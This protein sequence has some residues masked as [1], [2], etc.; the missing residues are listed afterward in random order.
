MG[1]SVLEAASIAAIKANAKGNLAIE[2][3][4]V[5]APPP[6][7]PAPKPRILGINT[8][9]SWGEAPAKAFIKAGITSSRIDLG[10]GDSISQALAYGFK[11]LLAIVGN[12][13]NS[14]PLSSVSETEWLA[15]ATAQCKVCAEYGVELCEGGNEM[16]G[17]GT[18]PNNE[19]ALYGRRMLALAESVKKAG[20]PIKLLANLYE[21]SPAAARRGA[22]P[23]DG[24]KAHHA[25][26][27]E[28]VAAG[29]L[30]PMLAAAPGLKTLLGGF[31]AHPY[32]LPGWEWGEGGMIA[33]RELAVKLGVQVCD[34]YVTEFGVECESTNAIAGYSAP[35]PA[36]QAEMTLAMYRSLL[37]LPEVKGIWGY[38]SHDEGSGAAGAA[39]KWGWMTTASVA[40]PVLA[41]IGAL[42]GQ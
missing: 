39:G 1:N 23:S 29:W 26:A 15:K 7:P 36:K 22:F 34:L 6:T 30:E 8:G 41:A 28:A 31:T 24:L 2:Y 13:P 5:A 33:Q 18:W 21:F 37:A 40:R 27:R 10:R 14:T 20:Y 16:Y 35:T 42:A 9:G 3:T 19:G 25:T 12:T 11:D 38:N 4:P 32:G 17:K